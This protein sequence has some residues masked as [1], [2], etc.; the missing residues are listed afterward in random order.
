MITLTKRAGQHEGSIDGIAVAVREQ[1]DAAQRANG[2]WFLSMNAT[3]TK[4]SAILKCSAQFFTLTEARAFANAVIE[5]AG[6]NPTR[7]QLLAAFDAVLA[8]PDAIVDLDAGTEPAGP[9]VVVP[10]GAQK[11]DQPAPA[12]KLYT[13]QHFAL[14]LRAA[15][16]LA[17]DQGA[18]VFILSALH[19][20][21]PLDRVLAPYD[22]KMGDRG[23]I[24]PA[25]LADQLHAIAPTTITAMLPKAYRTALERAGAEV[26]DLF[27]NAPG[28][29]YQRG[30]ASQ[31]L[32]SRQHATAVDPAGFVY[33][34]TLF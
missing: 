24:T 33:A 16:K 9:I 6:A 26:V 20:L 5:R 29:G 2:T 34:E 28:I 23:C 17:D 30:V 3:D 15:Q 7:L 13:S 10:C 22:V 14:T 21:V 32:A 8:G 25:E 11:L 31:I 27:A 19:G 4:L 18:R 1:T 12:A